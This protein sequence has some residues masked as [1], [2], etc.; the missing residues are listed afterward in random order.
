MASSQGSDSQS[1]GKPDSAGEIMLL[2]SDNDFDWS[3]FEIYFESYAATF[4]D[5]LKCLT[6]D[7]SKV[8]ETLAEKET[9]LDK[10]SIANARVYS[11]ILQ[12]GMHNPHARAVIAKHA[13]DDPERN[14]YKL[15]QLIK[16]RFTRQV[17]EIS[18]DLSNQLALI[19]ALPHEEPKAFIDRYDDLVRKI[20]A[21]N[22]ALLPTEII[23]L[24]ILKKAIEQ[25]F[26]LL[27]SAFTI[28]NTVW[29]LD[30][31]KEKIM[32]WKIENEPSYYAGPI[33]N[34]PGANKIVEKANFSAAAVAGQGNHNQRE[35]LKANQ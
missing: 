26:K 29:T 6:T 20:S 32:I 13:L 28:S 34:F 5:G 18:Q 12:A 15:F 9:R 21:I 25:R 11:A 30:L 8:V 31:W 1:S 22:T 33:I 17:V 23:Q 16:T 7:W 10:L 3:I 24:G 4:K 14:A 27:Y 35:N 19:V 2:T